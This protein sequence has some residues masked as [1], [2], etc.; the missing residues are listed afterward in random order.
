M[1]LGL[2]VGILA[3]LKTADEEG[4]RHFLDQFSQLNAALKTRAL[5]QHD[6]PEEVEQ[7]FSCNMI[8][9]SG[10]HYLRRIAM[11]IALGMPV[12]P[13]GTPDT[14]MA[15]DT[16]ENYYLRFCSGE[17]LDFQH[18]V[19]HSDAE[20]FYIP[21]DF[22]R[23]FEAQGVAGD[24]VG[25]TQRLHEECK[26]LAAVLQIPAGLCP[27]SEEVFGVLHTQ[28]EGVQQS[29]KGNWTWTPV[30]ERQAE[31]RWKT[32]PVEAYTC[33]QLLRAC[34]ASLKTKAAIVFC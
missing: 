25:S 21:L 4:Y 18:L 10:L 33:L 22:M 13:P 29:K 2:E 26:V 34:E 15:E 3:D 17:D 23:V 32:Y 31:P 14:Y 8:G 9:Y 30:A 5:G 16:G 28:L 1:G 24:Y 7:L 12:P 27:E 20:G 19:V 6:E 11:Y